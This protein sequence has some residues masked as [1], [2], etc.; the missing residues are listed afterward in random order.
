MAL[1]ALVAGGSIVAFA[2]MSPDDS[3]GKK[4]AQPPQTQAN[5]AP[6]AAGQ[7]ARPLTAT[8]P[9]VQLQ[10]FVAGL[11]PDGCDVE[12]KP[13]NPNCKF[14]L[15]IGKKTPQK[16]HVA[17]DGRARLELRDVEVTGAD[18]TCTIAVTVHEPG[19]PPKTVHRGFRLNSHAQFADPNHTAAIPSFNCYLSSPSKIARAEKSR[20]RTK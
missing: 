14:H 1:A 5:P 10:L 7:P 2:G 19:Q 8:A 9:V 12:I 4:P 15:T 3:T 6:S 17:A 11:S 13:G 18:R 20:S 16:I